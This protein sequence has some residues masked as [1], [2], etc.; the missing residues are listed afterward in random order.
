MRKILLA[1]MVMAVLATGAAYAVDITVNMT[2]DIPTFLRMTLDTATATQTPGG[3]TP[4]ILN[5][6]WTTPSTEPAAG[7]Y[8]ASPDYT[9]TV[10]CNNDWQL[11]ISGPANLSFTEGTDTYD[12]ALEWQISDA[13]DFAGA[14]AWGSVAYGPTTH[15][16]AATSFVRYCHFRIPYTWD[17]KAGTYTGIVTFSAT[18]P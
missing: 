6:T 12:A 5:S 16:F 13:S 2:V 7:Q 11:E 10:Q 15:P 9:L 1:C 18:S 3:D 14:P 4:G 17:Q 8:V